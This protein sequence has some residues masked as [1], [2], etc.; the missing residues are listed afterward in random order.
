MRAFPVIHFRDIASAPSSCEEDM[1]RTSRGFTLIEMLIVVVLIV[2]GT[3]IAIPR[4]RPVMTRQQVD[5][6]AQLVASDMRSAFTSAA[7]GRIPIRVTFTPSSTN[8]TVASRV[9]GATVVKRQF[10]GTDLNVA[11]IAA[12]TA[13]LDIFPNGIATGADTIT[14]SGT[15]GY[16]RQVSV[17]RIG[18]VRVIPLP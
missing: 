2:I 3:M 17:S 1:S 15:G 9:T 12:T 14:V 10:S 16:S 6:A 5:R 4:I 8:Y 7:R 18:F 11:S 13:T